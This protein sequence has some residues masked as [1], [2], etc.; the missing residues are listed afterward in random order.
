MKYYGKLRIWVELKQGLKKQNCLK[1]M[2]NDV[3]KIKF[4]QC[5]AS[6]ICS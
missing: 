5:S 6:T 4:Q 3:E 1:D 2:W